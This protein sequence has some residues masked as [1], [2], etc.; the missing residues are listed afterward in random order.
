MRPSTRST[1]P[2]VA[3]SSATP[4]ATGQEA[5]R[6]ATRRL[7][8]IMFTDIVGY[9]ALMQEDEARAMRARDRQRRVLEHQIGRHGGRILQVYGDGTLS[10]FDSAVAAVDAA[11]A[12]QLELASEPR[13]PL[14]VGIHTG[15]IVYDADGVFGDG[16][17]VASRI[18]S[19]GTPGSVLVSAKVQDEIKN[20][21]GRSAVSLGQFN[22][23]NVNRPIEV[24]AMV[25]Q[26]LA[27]P[28]PDALPGRRTRQGRSV[29][30]LPFLN[31]SA[32]PENEYFS[33]GITEELINVLTRVNGMQVTARTSS[34][35]FKGRHDDV[36][37]IASKLGVETVLEGSVRRA[38]DRI[39][40][41]AQLIDA[42][43]GYH[44]VSRSWDRRLAD[45]FELQDELAQAIVTAVQ[46]QLA[47]AQQPSLTTRR[48]DAKAHALY[49]HGLA[50]LARFTPEATR[51]AIEYFQ[52]AL[53]IDPAYEPA[54]ATKAWAHTTLAATGQAVQSSWND[55]EE[56]ASRAV[57]LDASS[58]E[59]HLALGAVRLYYHWD[60]DGGYQEVQ[61]ALGLNPGSAVAH[62]SFGKYLTIIGE[63]E[64]ACEQFESAIRL[65][66]LALSP[67]LFLAGAL[68][69]GGRFADAIAVADR[70]LEADPTFRA[71]IEARGVALFFDGRLDEAERTL[72]RF[73]AMTG[74][75]YKGL[76]PRG[77]LYASAG[78]TAE[79]QRVIEMLH[80]RQRMH[81]EL[82]LQ[83]DL[84]IVHA[85]L[86]EY[87][88]A[89]D[90][91]EEAGR[92][93]LAEVLHCVHSRVWEPIRRAPGFQPLIVRLGLSR[94]AVS[95]SYAS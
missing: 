47:P 89:L 92:R 49:L 63:F 65:D 85:A 81:P 75:P 74:D 68:I 5:P 39:R 42:S 59:A 4:A 41:T 54:W 34:F 94:L 30:V 71:A 76:A 40:V 67:Q 8:A 91:L 72:A 58:G 78:R 6:G 19:L 93:R 66:P 25:A 31:M 48:T 64:R 12:I 22:L 79:A 24:F 35:A 17:N 57:A 9:T 28:Q 33:D 11:V 45:I 38:G 55:A 15:D 90:Y 70:V 37:E 27:V 1:S 43:N 53:Q 13:V 3:E 84:A 18:Q 16:V 95:R 62:V 52:R 44:L 69:H 14:R 82:S 20:Q 46:D 80:E 87:D 56:A 61:K 23:R 51:R 50:E 36:R 7:S 10:V 2:A 29:A 26:G 73:V 21:S 83:I 32:D 86:G 88:R 77:Y 60:L